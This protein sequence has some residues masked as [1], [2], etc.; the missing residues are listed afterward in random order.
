[1][2]DLGKK[3]LG[4]KLMAITLLLTMV[5]TMLPVTEVQAK[6]PTFSKKIYLKCYPNRTNKNITYGTAQYIYNPTTNGKVTQ[7]KSSNPKVA[8]VSKLKHD[9]NSI[10][11]APKKAGK[12]KITFKYAG[13]KFTSTVIVVEHENPFKSIKIG[14]KNITKY[15][16]VSDHYAMNKQTKALKGKIN[17]KLNK[18]W[19]IE[20]INIRDKQYNTKKVKNKSNVKLESDSTLVIRVRNKKTKR[21]D[22][23]QFDYSDKKYESE[24]FYRTYTLEE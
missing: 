7:L 4:K 2:K 14:K 19:K 22:Q 11:I 8:T 3:I 15:F 6:S 16:N 13:K 1:M 23:I 17:I 21:L 10:I 5:I 24:N 18:D 12:A 20:Y 9:K